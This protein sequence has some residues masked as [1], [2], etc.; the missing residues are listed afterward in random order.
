AR[1]LGFQEGESQFGEFPWVAAVLRVESLSGLKL[2]RFVG[3]GTLIHPR[4]VVTAAHKVK[5]YNK[6][7]MVVRLGE[8]DTQ[9]EQEPYRHQDVA[10][11]D[12][13]LH[14]GFVLQTLYHDVALLI[15]KEESKF[16]SHIDSICLA[17]DLSLVDPSACVINGWGLSGFENGEYQ[18]IMKSLTLP[19]VQYKDCV[20]SLRTT[21]LGRYFRLHPSFT[22]AGGEKGKDA[23]R[24]DGGGPLACPRKEDP[25]RYLLVGITAWGIGCGQDG[26]P[27]VYNA[28]A[29]DSEGSEVE[30]RS[31]TEAITREENNQGRQ[32]G[33]KEQRLEKRKQQ[34]EERERRRQEKEESREERR[35]LREE[36]QRERLE[37]KEIRRRNRGF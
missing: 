37:A 28:A 22:C 12:I 25:K 35:R 33:A 13:V 14:P 9:S 17:Q 8:W 1:I 19:L 32:H 7:D 5:G 10:V 26:I 2:R 27:G 20:N 16:A 6:S 21:R 11:D 4:V 3:G 15:L 29:N 24:G 23:C 30:G 34:R 31:D 18:R 36:R